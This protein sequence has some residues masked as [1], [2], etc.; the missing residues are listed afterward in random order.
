MVSAPSGCQS[1]RSVHH[2][3][4][5]L[6]SGMGGSGA[7]RFIL[8]EAHLMALPLELLGEA[9]GEVAEHIR[10]RVPLLWAGLSVIG[11]NT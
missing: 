11:G 5:I 1:I 10:Q 4:H 3:K 8:E 6:V 9:L 2:A 7:A